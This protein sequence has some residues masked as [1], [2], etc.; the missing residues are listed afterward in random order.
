MAHSFFVSDLHG[1][2][3]RYR[4]L[5]RS[6]TD[7]PPQAL[8]IGGDILPHGLASR[9]T[10]YLESS[11]FIDGYLA[12]EFLR[13]KQQL[14]D[15]YPRIFIILGNDDGRSEES[16]I[17]KNAE[18]EVWEY[19]HLRRARLGKYTV[20]GYAYVPPTPFL[21]KDWERYDVSRYVDPGCVSP[22]EGWRT[23][24]IT[25][26]EARFSTI[27]DDLE[28]LTGGDRLDRAIILFHTPPYHTHLDRAALDGKMVDH[29]PL[30]VNVGSVAVRRFIKRRQPHITLHGHIHESVR[31]TGSWQDRIGRTFCFS[32]AHHGP[33]LALIRFD[34]DRPEDAR[35]F[36]LTD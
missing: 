17:L 27:A 11:N 6:I 19:V 10:E 28:T 22:E 1:R 3:S 26:D 36:L 33:E 12:E 29:V 34:P 32:A 21:L 24:S 23:V 35:R 8:F 20:F 13:L 4:A 16:A 18:R 15:R 30:D 9:S 14:G 2:I 31:L 5:F 7:D 25:E